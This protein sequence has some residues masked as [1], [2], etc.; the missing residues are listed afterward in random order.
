[1]TVACFGC[2]KPA[3]NAVAVTLRDKPVGDG[4]V[5]DE[6]VGGKA[7]AALRDEHRRLF[8][9]GVSLELIELMIRK[10]IEGARA[11]A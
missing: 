3:A 9:Q 6:C 10:R 11:Q 2:G 4:F 7:I 8:E 1:M 5:C